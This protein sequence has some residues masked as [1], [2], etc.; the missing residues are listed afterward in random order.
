MKPNL[1]IVGDSYVMPN[2][3]TKQWIDHTKGWPYLLG[4]S[5]DVD[6]TSVIGQYGCANTYICY[7][8]KK[9]SIHM[10]PN[11][12]LVVVTTSYTRKWFFFDEPQYTNAK[13]IFDNIDKKHKKAI[14]QYYIYLDDNNESKF[15]DFENMIAWCHIFAQRKNLRLAIIPC[16]EWNHLHTC[17][18]GSL[19]NIDLHEHGGSDK[20][21]K[22]LDDNNKQ[23]TKDCHLSPENHII[24]T[25]RLTDF[26]TH[27]KEID[28]SNGFVKDLF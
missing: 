15:I 28:L 9:N 11:D 22:W 1:W 2:M 27:N 20:K 18:D 14:E 6:T 12:Y 3:K 17:L 16:F 19:Y 13:V 10:K 24:L 5:L 26:F 21:Q 7:E 8:I 25:Q 4:K 23:D